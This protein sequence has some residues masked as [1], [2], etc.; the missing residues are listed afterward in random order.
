MVY[1]FVYFFEHLKQ[2][3]WKMLLIDEN[4]RKRWEEVS[5]K[6]EMKTFSHLHV[7]KYAAKC[8]FFILCFVKKKES[9]RF[10]A[11]IHL[12]IKGDGQ[13]IIWCNLELN[14]FVY[15]SFPSL[16]I[17]LKKEKCQLYW[18]QYDCSMLIL[19]CTENI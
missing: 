6:M 19:Y 17:A 15:R 7:C 5:K 2:S 11:N 3:K 16:S 4:E 1:M 13:Y 18:G 8:R 14:V 10:A 9:F 12:F